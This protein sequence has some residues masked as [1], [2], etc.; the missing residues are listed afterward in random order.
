MPL[1]MLAGLAISS[2]PSIF[3]MIQGASQLGKAKKMKVERP[4]YQTPNEVLDATS[5]YRQLAGTNRL[6]GQSY[7]EDNINKSTSTSIRSAANAGGSSAQILSTIAGLNANENEATNQLQVQGAQNQMQNQ[8]RLGQQLG[9]Q[10]GYRDKEFEY[11]KDQPFQDAANTRSALYGA[12]QQNLMGGLD[13]L[14][15]SATT[16]LGTNAFDG[17]SSFFKDMAKRRAL[18]RELGRVKRM[19]LTPMQSGNVFQNDPMA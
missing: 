1:P 6:A 3:K 11:N 7:A 2:I 10:A 8:G 4:T 13:G 9:V 19:P 12:G 15:G 18:S 5:M 16:A 17:V 14:A